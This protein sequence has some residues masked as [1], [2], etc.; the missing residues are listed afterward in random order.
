MT[1]RLH[2]GVKFVTFLSF[3]Q[4]LSQGSCTL[5]RAVAP[6]ATDT[7]TTPAEGVLTAEEPAYLAVPI[8]KN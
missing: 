5:S 8:C 6:Q 4:R 3:K 7:F 1:G 2:P